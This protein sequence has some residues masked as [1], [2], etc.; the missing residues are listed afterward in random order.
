MNMALKVNWLIVSSCV[1]SSALYIQFIPSKAADATLSD[2]A[3]TWVVPSDFQTVVTLHLTD[4]GMYLQIIDFRRQP[5]RVV[6]HSGHFS[7][8]KGSLHLYQYHNTHDQTVGT[9]EWEIFRRN[10]E[11][12]LHGHDHPDPDAFEYISRQ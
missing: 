5:S 1:L 10:S 11:I 2:M 6:Q 3:G 9:V 7:I 12:L 8:V 4:D